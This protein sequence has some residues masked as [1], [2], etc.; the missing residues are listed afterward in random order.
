[1][2]DM[3]IN[4][5][6]LI[7]KEGLAE[8][9][10]Y[11]RQHRHTP[12]ERR[13]T[14]QPDRYL[15]RS[16]R[17]RRSGITFDQ[18]RFEDA[19]AFDFARSLATK[20][21]LTL[22]PDLQPPR[23]PESTDRSAAALRAALTKGHDLGSPTNWHIETAGADVRFSTPSGPNANVPALVLRTPEW[24]DPAPRDLI[25]EHRTRL[26]AVKNAKDLAAF[27]NEVLD[28]E[29]AYL[30]A[31]D[32]GR[33][34]NQTFAVQSHR[35]K[36]LIE[37][38]RQKLMT[39]PPAELARAQAMLVEVDERLVIGRP[40]QMETG[41]QLNYWPYWQNYLEALKDVAELQP[42]D[43]G[44]HQVL[45]NRVRDVLRRRTI[46]GEGDQVDEQDFETSMEAALVYQPKYRRG[47]GHRVSL[48]AASV[49]LRPRYELLTL[50]TRGLPPAW[51]AHAGARLFYD[52]GTIRFDAD[53]AGPSQAPLPDDLWPF[54]Q[55]RTLRPRALRDG[56]SLRK[57]GPEE[58]ARSGVPADWNGN[59]MIDAAPIVVEWW[60]HCH[61][62]APANAMSLE[63]RKPTT[64]YTADR[65]VP[66]DRALKTF[67]VDRVWDIFGALA[68]SQ[69]LGFQSLNRGRPTTVGR[70]TVAGARHDGHHRLILNLGDRQIHLAAELT[71]HGDPN[72]AP[73]RY[74][75]RADG[76]FFENP[77]CRPGPRRRPRS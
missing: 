13:A 62:E 39:L 20:Y 15:K 69:D 60:G 42:H 11:A 66:A 40:F 16:E 30:M 75:V 56:L 12:S 64:V 31:E 28:R 53:T 4:S 74:I 76:T 14:V 55:R 9:D 61:N 34:N 32:V 36:A 41:H 51:R 49:P 6:G 19:E 50:P 44:R 57:L 47:P 29:W 8:I 58:T 22:P 63:P 23:P 73:R 10:A 5:G 33:S 25:D 52:G 2:V 1:M 21:G 17:L 43:C 37:G 38:L 70:S 67:S 48:A 54:V 7:T 77:A 65:G 3:L 71:A 26:G 45:S 68:A 46:F 24:A 18:V 72:A 35:R 59:G 27:T